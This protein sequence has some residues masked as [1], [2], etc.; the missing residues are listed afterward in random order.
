MD[1]PS[2]ARSRVMAIG[3]D[4]THIFGLVVT[5]CLGSGPDGQSRSGSASE[6]RPLTAS[7]AIRV[8]R[9]RSD[10]S[11]HHPMS[12]ARHPD[13]DPASIVVCSGARHD[14]LIGP[15]R[16]QQSPEN[17]GLLGGEG[18]DGFIEAAPRV[19][20]RDPA[21]GDIGTPGEVSHDGARPLN[22]HGTEGDIPAL[23]NPAQAS[24]AATGMLPRDQAPPGGQWAPLAEGACIAPRGEQR[25]RRHGSDARHLHPPLSRLRL[26]SQVVYAAIIGH[27]PR[28]HG[29]HPIRQIREDLTRQRRQLGGVHER[30]QGPPQCPDPRRHD[31][32]LFGQHS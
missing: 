3:S 25:R 2:G 12:L 31:Q 19:E 13:A 6:T 15:S 11:R 10:R 20:R 4:C 22:E 17:P 28:I 9:R 1:S 26:P 7:P 5:P 16:G 8:S 23:G 30:G 24:S 27:D 18:H 21:A 29:A 32:P 14:G